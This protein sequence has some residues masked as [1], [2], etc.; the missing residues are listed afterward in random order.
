MSERDSKKFRGN[1]MNRS[2]SQ[3]D[4]KGK[5]DNKI[6][7]DDFDFE[8]FDIKELEKSG[9]SIRLNEKCTG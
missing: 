9:W 8:F 6:I 1:I 4:N 5:V 7:S 2:H 3:Q